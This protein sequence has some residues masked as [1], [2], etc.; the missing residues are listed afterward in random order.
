M[1]FI[2][3]I[4]NFFIIALALRGVGALLISEINFP[5]DHVSIHKDKV[6]DASA[7]DK[8][9]EDLMTAE[10]CMPA[11]E[12]RQL[13]RIDHA[14]DRVDHAARQEPKKR[15]SRQCRKEFSKYQ[16]THPSHRNIDDG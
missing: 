14:A 9:V 15:F 12:N 5:L 6:A 11:V 16:N 2:T 13:Q 1:F 3:H 4:D 7:H 8:Q 10:V